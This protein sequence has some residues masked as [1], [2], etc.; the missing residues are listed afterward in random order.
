MAPVLVRL[1][2]RKDESTMDSMAASP[3]CTPK[4][5]TFTMPERMDWHRMTISS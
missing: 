2:A 1:A 4:R 5:E 3:A